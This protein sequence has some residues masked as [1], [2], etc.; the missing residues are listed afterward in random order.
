[1]AISCSLGSIQNSVPALP[2]QPYSPIEPGSAES[3]T[4]VRTSKPRPKPKPGGR[5]GRLPTW[6]A[7][8]KSSVL[9]AEHALAGKLAAVGKHGR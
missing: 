5:P 7:V 8:M 3:P 1:M 2:A 9:L 4:L 6:S